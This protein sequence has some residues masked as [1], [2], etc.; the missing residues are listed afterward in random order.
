MIR[1]RIPALLLATTLLFLAYSQVPNE[2]FRQRSLAAEKAGLAEAFRGVTTQGAVEPGLFPLRSTGVSTEPARRGAAAFLAA[3]TP[4][5]RAETLFPVDD[6]EWRKWMNQD[7][8]VR[9]GVSFLAMTP[10][11][12]EAAFGMLRGALSAKGL[13]LS[14][15]LMKLNETLGELNNNNFERY[16]EGRYW[17]TVMGEPSKD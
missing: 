1:L 15:D 11:Q 12:R 14:Q 4:E 13:K 16:G 7:F 2:A 6:V 17:L 5:Q 8:Y 3:L 10:A 9:Q